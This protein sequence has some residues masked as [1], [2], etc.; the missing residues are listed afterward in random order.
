[1]LVISLSKC[2]KS[3]L[4]SNNGMQGGVIY[5]VLILAQSMPAKNLWSM[6]SSMPLLSVPLPAFS[7]DLHP[8]LQLGSLLSSLLI[9][10]MALGEWKVQKLGFLTRMLVKISCLFLLQK[11]GNPVSIS[12]TTQPKLHKSQAFPQ[13]C[14]LM[15][16]GAKYSV[17]PQKLE[18]YPPPF[19]FTPP[20][21]S[22]LDNPKSVNTANPDLSIRMFSGFKL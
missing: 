16:S 10:S 12:Y 19:P 4:L 13:V 6:I 7:L 11:G 14:F 18:A 9:K 3:V 21:K 15:I 5:L 1:M 8:N 17:V 20:A 2:F 22:Y